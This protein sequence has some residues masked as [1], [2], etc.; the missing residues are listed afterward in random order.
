[1]EITFRETSVDAGEWDDAAFRDAYWAASA[2]E[3]MRGLD[4]T[5]EDDLA[6][7]EVAP[8]DEAA[9]LA[10]E[11]LDVET[12]VRRARAA[13]A[14]QDWLFH[15]VLTRA[16]ADPTPWVGADPTLDPLWVDPRKRSHAQVRADRRMI[17]VRSAAADLGVRVHLSDNQVRQRA[18]RAQVLAQRCPAA[19]ESCLRGDVSEQNAAITADVAGSL[20]D[21]DRDAWAAFDAAV[22][23]AAATTA[24][25]RYRIRARA[26][27]ERVVSEPLEIRHRRAVERRRV[28]LEAEY[29]GM[30]TLTAVIPAVT[31]HAID[32]GLDDYARQLATA[33]G[34]TRTLAQLRADV[35]GDLLLGA[36][37]ATVSALGAQHPDAGQTS[38]ESADAG[39]VAPGPVAAKPGITPTVRITIP[40]L[41]LLGRSDEP[42]TLDGYGPIPLDRAIE[43]AGGAKSWIRVLTH[44]VSG[45]VMDVDRRAYRVP[46]DLRRLLEIRHPTCVFPGCNRPSDRCDMDHRR[47]WADGGTTSVG[48]LA[49]EC[50]RHHPVKDESLWQLHREHD[51][52]PLHWITPTGLRV[53]EDPPPF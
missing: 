22:S 9:S 17:A 38:A 51:S 15:V 27:R 44:P 24:P 16:E 23:D 5:Y 49:P 2:D 34:E 29:D 33:D 40:A 10:D 3:R 6:Y 43:L 25:A 52:G 47:R 30:A 18:H 12:A 42:A 53:D 37:P 26:A 13:A 8:L 35:F 39:P 14:E 7:P 1:M 19:W 46:A 4:A 32:R 11:L 41:T 50:E 36:G 31:A 28:E 48:N 45:T 21:D 20:P